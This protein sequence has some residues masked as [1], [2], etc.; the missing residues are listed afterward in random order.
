MRLRAQIIV[1]ISADGY[2][3]AAAHQQLLERFLNDV[4]KKYP[5]A[6]LLMRERRERRAEPIASAAH[7][8]R[9]LSISKGSAK[10][11]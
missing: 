3:E 9:Q 1:D 5:D 7:E 2:V 10:L 8:V 11:P 6:R 4:Q